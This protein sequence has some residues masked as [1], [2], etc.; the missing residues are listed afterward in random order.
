MEEHDHI[1]LPCKDGAKIMYVKKFEHL[2][3]LCLFVEGDDFL[4]LPVCDTVYRP[5][6]EREKAKGLIGVNLD[7]SVHL[8]QFPDC[9]H[10][11]KLS[12]LEQNL[13]HS[14]SVATPT[15]VLFVC[16]L[17]SGTCVSL[18]CL[19]VVTWC[20]VCF[21]LQ[22]FWYGKSNAVHELPSQRDCL[23]VLFQ[24]LC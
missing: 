7:L 11:F 12:L 2:K 22:V 6:I 18:L 21:L 24:F 4:K 15:P 3:T 16:W 20:F 5:A 23:S 17:L 13:H 1:G 9:V 10:D 8:Q 14:T 19:L